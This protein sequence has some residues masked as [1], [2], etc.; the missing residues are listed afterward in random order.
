MD[1]FIG[2]GDDDQYD[3]FGNY[4]GSLNNTKSSS[5]TVHEQEAEQV[6]PHRDVLLDSLQNDSDYS[7]ESDEEVETLI[8]YQD[9]QPISQPLVRSIPASRSADTETSSKTKKKSSNRQN[10]K[11]ASSPEYTNYWSTLQ[12]NSSKLYNLAIIGNAGHGKST[13]AREILKAQ[14]ILDA[15]LPK[16]VWH[17]RVKVN[18]TENQQKTHMMPSKNCLSLVPRTALERAKDIGLLTRAM[19]CCLIH[20]QKHS[21]NMLTMMDSPGHL[22]VPEQLEMTCRLSDAAMVVVDAVEGVLAGTRL[23]MASAVQKHGIP[24][25]LFINKMD[26]LIVD[27]K[28]APSDAYHKLCHLIDEANAVMS[29]LLEDANRKFFF[30]LKTE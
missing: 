8:Q 26:R 9:A 25:L 21:T 5:F 2:D 7:D 29:E 28:L 16:K 27:L 3:E 30:H 19:S 12:F 10:T 17:R 11:T 22:G 15:K 1:P 4:I 6:Q 14:V 20:P 23:A 13:L 24:C 18:S